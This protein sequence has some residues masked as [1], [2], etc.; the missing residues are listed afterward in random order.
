[1]VSRRV[2]PV[3]FA[4]CVVVGTFTGCSDGGGDADATVAFAP[5]TVV[6]TDAGDADRSPWTWGWDTAGVTSVTLTMDVTQSIAVGDADASEAPLPTVTSTLSLAPRSPAP[7]G[8]DVAAD[9]A[10]TG[11][12]TSGTELVVT[13]TDL[14]TSIE[15]L[16]LDDPELGDAVAGQSEAMAGLVGVE[17][18]VAVTASG[19]ITDVVPPTADVELPVLT[20]LERTITELERLL[21]QWPAEP[22]GEGARWTVTSVRTSQGIH[23]EVT[24]HW[25]L[26]SVEGS[27]AEVSFTITEV[28]V[29]QEVPVAEG[30]E[31]SGVIEGAGVVTV[32]PAAARIVAGELTTELEATVFDGD[33]VA[34]TTANRI[35]TVASG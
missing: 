25:R 11:A 29:R 2:V 8:A 24:T 13:V 17:A 15:G 20:Q 1:M 33:G 16:G 5:G 10:D 30:R 3:L 28:A 23:W 32:D 7:T 14:T 18:V 4:A 34:A 31:I 9:S 35:E 21:V 27:R 6:V 12:A 26:E 19:A 22:V